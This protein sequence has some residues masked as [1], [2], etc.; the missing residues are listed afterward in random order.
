MSQN[1]TANRT[2]QNN[3]NYHAIR[4]IITMNIIIYI[5]LKKPKLLHLIKIVSNLATKRFYKIN[6]FSRLN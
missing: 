1:A 6:M 3:I 5:Q 2:S 4:K